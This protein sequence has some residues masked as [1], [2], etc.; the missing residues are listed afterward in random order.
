MMM[1]RP[2][3]DQLNMNLQGEIQASDLKKPYPIRRFQ[4]PGAKVE[5]Q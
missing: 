4:C 2:H 5:N 1:L 3:R